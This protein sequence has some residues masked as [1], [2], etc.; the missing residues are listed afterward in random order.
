MT[1]PVQLDLNEH[2]LNAST[3]LRRRHYVNN[4]DGIIPVDKEDNARTTLVKTFE[5]LHLATILHSA[6]LNI[7]LCVFTLRLFAVI[8]PSKQS[9]KS[10]VFLE[11]RIVDFVLSI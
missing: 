7:L 1:W 11:Q 4:R 6:P 8:D 5:G 9:L 3:G 2:G 10:A